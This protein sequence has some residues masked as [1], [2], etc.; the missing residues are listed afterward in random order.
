MPINS[1][2]LNKKM[3][4]LLK[5]RGYN[6]IPKD[7]EGQT[8]PVPDEAEVI[9]FTFSAD[10]KDYGEVWVTIDSSQNLIIYFGDDVTDSDDDVSPPNNWTSLLNHLKNW[11]QRR[12]LSFELKNKNHLAS[13]MAQRSHMKKKEQIAENAKWR[14]GYSASGHPAGYKHKNGD[15]GPI[16]GTFTNEPSGYDGE[17]SKVP[18]QKHRDKPDELANRG[19]LKVSTSGKPLLPKNAQ[20]NL[21]AAIEKSKGKHGPVGVLP[22]NI[23]EG[24]HP[25]GKSASYND[26]VP[27]VKIVLQHTRQVQE[28]EQRFRNVAKIFLENQQGERILCPSTKPGIAQ[29]YAR[30][31]AEGGLPHD[32]RWNHIG[33]L[34]EEY[35]KMAGFVRAT[36]NGQFNESAQQ[37]VNE[38]INHYNTL[39]ETLGKMRGHRGYQAYFESYTP[40]LMETEGDESINELF[41]RETMDP[42]IESVMPILARLHKK[43]NE[44]S[45]VS[46][47]AGWADELIE[48]HPNDINEEESLTSN[49]PVGIPES[50]A[51]DVIDQADLA[52][53]MQAI[54]KMQLM[55]G[56]TGIPSKKINF[57]AL[58]NHL[59]KKAKEKGIDTSRYELEEDLGPEQVAA[60]QLGP[61][62]RPAKQGDLVGACE[63]VE[64]GTYNKDVERAFPGGKASGVKTGASAPKGTS[65]MPKDKEKAKGKSVGVTE[66]QEPNK[67]DEVY[68]NGKRVGWFVGYSPK[69]R[70]IVEPDLEVLGQ[71]YK[72]RQ[73][74][75][76]PKILKIKP[77]S[78]HQSTELNEMDSEGYKGTRD[79]D[80]KGPEGKATPV[81][82]KD[83]AKDALK[84]LNKAMDKANKKDVSEGQ[85]DLDAIRKMLGEGWKGELAGGT[86][87]GVGGTVAG[88]ALGALAGG[89]VGAAIG[90]VVGGA[91]GGTA[92]QLAGRELTKEEQLNEVG[93]LLAAGARAIIP[94]LSRIGPALGRMAA[95][96]GRATANMAGKAATGVGRGAVEVGK[97]AAQSAAQN[98][99]KIGLGVGAYQAITDVANSMVGGVGQ[100]YNDIGSAASEIAKVVGGA[101]DSA[102]IRSLAEAAVKYAIPIGILLAVVYGG[103]KLIDKVMSEGTDDTLAGVAGQ[104]IGRVTPN[105]NDFVKGF[106]KQFEGVNEGQEDLDAILRIVRK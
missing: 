60:G 69:G 70:V 92:G 91:A 94:L 77:A 35:S 20:K 66:G 53:K 36:R 37:L 80:N 17:T 54:Q 102:A 18:V 99:G 89:P 1:D 32:D 65:T 7:S 47:L 15:V 50:L 6:P 74:H 39:R 21:K 81:K 98:A 83:A 48:G 100:V 2:S 19:S 40:N 38:G 41:V 67:G 46:E 30:H 14:Q 79:E 90:G 45:E 86:L 42:R 76:N 57:L 103:K 85:E 101:I 13:D 58:K 104:A 93:P 22:E 59:L 52:S 8:T 105:P 31:L 34:V 72:G 11:A 95:G 10:G 51:E 33:S 75:W 68:W 25:M 73:P 87:G 71:E 29:I 5:I 28:G 23:A 43:V 61:T 96:A 26:A 27:T 24:Y 56:K 97:S 84:T 49:N 44:M 64:E 78:T 3:Y 55:P 63:S 82:A 12:Q 62:G 88:S 4:N 16:G 9:K 106:N